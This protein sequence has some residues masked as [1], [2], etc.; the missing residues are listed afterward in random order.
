M[1]HKLVVLG[2]SVGMSGS[3]QLDLSRAKLDWIHS[4]MQNKFLPLHVLMQ[5]KDIVSA[6]SRLDKEI[7]GCSIYK[8]NPL[9]MIII[10]PTDG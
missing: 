1:S 8:I 6:D 3:W 9:P 2:L 10:F 5:G 7:A 4:N